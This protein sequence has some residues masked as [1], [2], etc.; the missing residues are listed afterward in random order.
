M[1]THSFFHSFI[2][3]SFI[4]SL[5]HSSSWFAGLGIELRPFHMLV[6]HHWAIS[7][8]CFSIFHLE[9]ESHWVA[10]ADLGLAI[11][12]LLSLSDSWN[13]RNAP[14]DQVWFCFIVKAK[15]RGM[16]LCPFPWP[17]LCFSWSFRSALP[18][19]VRMLR[20]LTCLLA[21]TESP[22]RNVC[23]SPSIQLLLNFSPLYI[24][25]INTLII[26]PWHSS[27]V[28]IHLLNILI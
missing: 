24:L 4:H 11:C 28:S 12:F 14:P 26:W 20:L 27:T 19:W 6:L 16:R 15:W 3:Y 18:R 1:F 23:L 13:D 7:P 5:T 9:S 17:F 25:N 10:Q 22:L 8:D 2:I 21:I